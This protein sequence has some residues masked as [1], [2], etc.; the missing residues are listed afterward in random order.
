[1]VVD[2]KNIRLMMMIIETGWCDGWLKDDMV[3]T[4]RRWQDGYNNVMVVY[5]EKIIFLMMIMDILRM[6]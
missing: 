5:N 2:E 6:W 4:W 1:M 3:M